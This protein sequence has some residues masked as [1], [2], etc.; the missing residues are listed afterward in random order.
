MSHNAL[1]HPVLLSESN[2]HG[3]LRICFRNTLRR[4]GNPSVIRK[5]QNGKNRD[6][7]ELRFAKF[8]EF[9]INISLPRVDQ[10][11][12]RENGNFSVSIQVG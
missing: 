5:Q 1:I 9:T 12:W 7:R 4:R 10:S 2:F 11:R 8:R 3:L 6:Y